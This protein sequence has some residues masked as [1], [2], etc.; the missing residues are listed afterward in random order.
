VV[1][2]VVAGL[3]PL[4]RDV[5]SGAATPPG[6][7]TV[8]KAALMRLRVAA[9]L[10]AAPAPGTPVDAGAVS[11]IL[12]EIDGLLSEV[13]AL[14]HTATPEEQGS[15]EAMRNALVKEA[16]DFSEAAQRLAPGEGDTAA[17]KVRA[18][19]ARARVL[20]VERGEEKGGRKRRALFVVLAVC[21]LGG[22]AFHAVR[23][24]RRE[25][26]TPLPTLAGAP[27]NATALSGAP[28]P[29][30]PGLTV[31]RSTDG[32]PFRPD[33][34]AALAEAERVKGN[35]VKELGPGVLVILPPGAQ[36]P[37]GANDAR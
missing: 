5:L 6:A 8:R 20:S 28:R 1:E 31:V 33:E 9:A 2:A 27:A 13:G 21:L 22:G 24:A 10:A 17:P 19:V 30:A 25:E 23:L 36:A 37:R 3:S 26:P 29:G 14:V 7:D 16:I 12:A 15:L 34:V 18:A 32:R 4:E 35:V 11:A